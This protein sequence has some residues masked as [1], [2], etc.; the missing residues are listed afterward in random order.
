MA[1]DLKSLD[2]YYQMKSIKAK[3]FFCRANDAA[4]AEE[5]RGLDKK[6]EEP[7][8]EVPRADPEANRGEDEARRSVQNKYVPSK[9]ASCYVFFSSLLPL[10]LI[11]KSLFSF[12]EHITLIN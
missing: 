5:S 4:R 1:L 12:L 7:R 8:P 3:Y 9:S 2:Q 6:Q 10:Q 11:L